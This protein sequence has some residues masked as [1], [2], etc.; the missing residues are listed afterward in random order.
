VTYQLGKTSEANL[1][2]VH[3]D[4]VAVVRDAITFTGQDF[5]V[6]EGLR[7]QARQDLLFA[8][9][10]SRTL[11]SYH[12]TGDAV[13]L[14]PYIAGRVQWQAPACLKVAVAMQAAAR[15]HQVNLTWGAVWDREL[16]EMAQSDLQGEID[17]YVQRYRRIHGPDAHP[18]IDYPHFQ[19][20]RS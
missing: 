6:F 15:I 13:D 10:V 17:R 12:L 5:T 19:R 14:V 18:L 20:V 8:S 2:G 4:L 9:G 7:S 1:Q 16:G 11:N 3:R